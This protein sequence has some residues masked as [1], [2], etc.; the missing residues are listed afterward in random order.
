M[1]GE[2]DGERDSRRDGGRD[3]WEEME[4]DRDREVGRE[5]KRHRDT[6]RNREE[7]GEERVGMSGVNMEQYGKLVRGGGGGGQAQEHLGLRTQRQTGNSPRYSMEFR[8]RSGGQGP[9][10]IFEVRGQK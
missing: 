2:I 8:G 3:V 10:N 6:V 7:D 5:M 1:K 9:P 4:R